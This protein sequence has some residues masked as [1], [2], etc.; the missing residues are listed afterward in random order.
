MILT[1]VDL[2]A[3]FSPSNASTEPPLATRSTPCKTSTPPNDLRIPRTSRWKPGERPTGRSLTSTFPTTRST[4]RC[5]STRRLAVLGL[6]VLRQ[7]RPVDDHVLDVERLRDG[8][9]LHELDEVRD[10]D[11]AVL[12]R[13][14]RRVGDPLLVV[15]DQAPGRRIGAL[16]RDVEVVHAPGGLGRRERAL[17]PVV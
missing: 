6:V 16:P 12:F 9:S 3:P 13:E 17:D 4:G 10:T 15:L 11:H 7:V 5:V 8:L 1:S 14:V 2:P